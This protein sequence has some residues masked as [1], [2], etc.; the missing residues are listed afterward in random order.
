MY[1]CSG[2]HSSSYFEQIVASIRCRAILLF[3]YSEILIDAMNGVL[4]W[5]SSRVVVSPRSNQ[6]Q[7]RRTLK[8]IAKATEFSN[9]SI[10]ITYKTSWDRPSIH[11]SINNNKWQSADLYQS[12]VVSQGQDWKTVSISNNQNELTS[13]E[14]AITNGNG[15]WDKLPDGS[16]YRITAAEADQTYSLSN[17]MLTHIKTPPVL[18]FTDLDDTLIGD[19]TATFTFTQWWQQT[20]VPAGGRLVYNTGRALDL[21]LEL[22]EEKKHFMPEPDAL[23][24]SVGTKIYTKSKE[25]KWNEFEGWTSKLNSGWDLGAVR[26][27]GYAAVASVSKDKLHFRPRSEMNEHKVT[28][29]VHVDVLDQTIE[30]LENMLQKDSI[31]Y[32]CI[33]SGIGEWRYMDIVPMR[34]GKFQ[35][36]TYVREEVFGFDN[37]STVACGDSGNDI[38]MLEGGDHH[39]V[40]VGNAQPD[41]LKWA[42]SLDGGRK[43]RRKPMLMKEHRSYGILEALHQLGFKN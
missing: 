26:E 7:T 2:N 29:G 21:F 43:R 32:K 14:F 22:Y 4:G 33:I 16:N 25:G 27:A 30:I 13:L 28:C 10:H 19:D 12:S 31:Q 41:L 39:A 35:A 34:A 42:D 24:S 9:K 36:L 1:Y 20:G 40:L 8:L 15:S 3:Y 23:I 5:K 38:D 11:F 37:E 6:D 17:G 18:L